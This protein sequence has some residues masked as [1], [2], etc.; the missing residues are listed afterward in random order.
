MPLAP[1]PVLRQLLFDA[2]QPAAERQRARI[3]VLRH[4]AEQ[5]RLADD[6]VQRVHHRPA[7]GVGPADRHVQLI[8][9]DDEDAVVRIGGLPQ[10]LADRTRI[11]ALGLRQARLDA[12]ELD[13]LDGLRL[14]V[15]EDLKVLGLQPFDDFSVTLRI[16]IDGDEDRLRRGRPEGVAAVS[17][18]P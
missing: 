3:G 11:A 17:V 5:V 18:A 7:G 8:E 10:H 14:A 2:E 6:P 16:D 9:K 13:V 12:H 4:H 15:F 1:G